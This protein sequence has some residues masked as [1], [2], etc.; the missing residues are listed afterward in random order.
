[1]GVCLYSNVAFVGIFHRNVLNLHFIFS[2]MCPCF[3]LQYGIVLDAGSSH[4]ALFIYKWP[5]GKE[6]GTGVVT[7]HSE[8]QAKGIFL[9]CQRFVFCGFLFV[10]MFHETVVKICCKCKW[11]TLYTLQ[12]ILITPW[13]P[14]MLFQVQSII[15]GKRD[16]HMYHMC[17]Y[18]AF[19]LFWARN[20]VVCICCIVKYKCRLI[21]Q[22]KLR[23]CAPDFPSMVMSRLFWSSFTLAG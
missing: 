23:S 21:R 19:P 17:T 13:P 22:N 2:Y 5:A 7:Q 4:T 11:L 18:D 12:K 10:L 9:Y 1:M 14:N 6:N 3:Q 16:K 15:L 8:C 20:T